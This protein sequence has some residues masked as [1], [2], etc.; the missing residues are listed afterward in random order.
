MLKSLR[1]I[2]VLAKPREHGVPEP[3]AFYLGERRIDVLEVMDRWLAADYGYFKL[4]TAEGIYILRHDDREQRWA[5][6]LYKR[7]E[8]LP[9]F[10]LEKKPKV[11]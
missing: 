9:G 5:L 1:P 7:W 4:R 2:V 6:T 11:H 10:E 3:F 8:S